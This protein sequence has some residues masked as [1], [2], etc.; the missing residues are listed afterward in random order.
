MGKKLKMWDSQSRVDFTTNS[1]L[2]YKFLIALLDLDRYVESTKRL[3]HNV[4]CIQDKDRKTRF[5]FPSRAFTRLVAATVH[6][7]RD[8]ISCMRWRIQGGPRVLL[9]PPP[10]TERKRITENVEIYPEIGYKR[11]TI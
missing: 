2:F 4:S 11:K 9:P 8:A 6:C 1:N 7:D 10:K 5:Q 3:F